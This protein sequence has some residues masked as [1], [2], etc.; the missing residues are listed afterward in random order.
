MKKNLSFLRIVL[1]TLCGIFLS[2]YTHA[3]TYNFIPSGDMENSNW[4][5][6]PGKT[7]LT[8]TFDASSGINGTTS[9]K[10]VTGNMGGDSYYIL[11]CEDAFRMVKSDKITVSFWAKGSADNMRLQPWVQESDGN[12]WMDFGDAYL[13]TNW[14]Q[15]RFTTTVSSQTSGNYK[16]K[17]RGY[18]TGTMYIDNVEIGPV[19]YEDVNQSGI[20]EVTVSQNGMTRPV[21]VFRNSCPA[22]Q[23]GYQNMDPKD[24][25]PLDY[26]AGRTINWT[27]FSFESPITVRVKIGRAHV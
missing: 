9:Y 10:T 18:N 17:F 7:N 20:Y 26:F 19:D 1:I 15:Y 12:Q 8:A 24:K 13:T 11:R 4:T 21:N 22:Y 6:V 5:G 25:I 27:K 3:Q 2:G 16:L 14:K 23:D